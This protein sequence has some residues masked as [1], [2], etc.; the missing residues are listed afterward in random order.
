MTQ[1]EGNWEVEVFYDGEC[2]LCMREM[3]MLMRRDRRAR[4]LFTNIAD[5]D[6]DPATTGRTWS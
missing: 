1:R 6:F 2:P 5:R 3:R 4:I